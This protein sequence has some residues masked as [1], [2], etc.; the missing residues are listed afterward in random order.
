[1][2]TEE[3]KEKLKTLFE[4]NGLDWAKQEI[5][6]VRFNAEKR[7]F[8]QTLVDQDEKQQNF[9]DAQLQKRKYSETLQQQKSSTKAT[10]MVAIG[11]ALL[12]LVTAILVI[13]TYYH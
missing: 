9:V 5:K 11:T 4:E 13:V 10:W 6:G 1:M 2:L 8:L 12:V 3:K 7:Q